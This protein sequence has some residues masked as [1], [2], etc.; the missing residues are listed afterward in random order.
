CTSGGRARASADVAMATA[1]E[2]PRSSSCS[3]STSSFAAPVAGI[4]G[5]SRG[6]LRQIEVADAEELERERPARRRDFNE[7]SGAEADESAADRRC[8]RYPAVA[9][10]RLDRADEL[11]LGDFVGVQLADADRAA[12]SGAAV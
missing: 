2:S 4:R 5:R 1:D 11:V 3:A 6:L 10:V 12:D 7:R 8:D 9:D